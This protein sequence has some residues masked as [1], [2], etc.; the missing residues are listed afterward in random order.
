[1]TTD[2]T[3]R[4]VE[5]AFYEALLESDPD[6]TGDFRSAVVVESARIDVIFADSDY[7]PRKEDHYARVEKL[8]SKTTSPTLTGA[9]EIEEGQM[10]V[11]I[12]TVIGGE[13]IVHNALEDEIR[14][15]F[16]LHAELARGDW[17]VRIM[18]VGS[19][20]RDR[21]EKWRRQTLD[22]AYIAHRTTNG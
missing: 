19:S 20:E 12:N 8:A 16:R 9:F 2:L 18:S 21:V 11:E 5:Y 13:S 4:S 1:M 7:K 6:N 3:H 15:K 10:R 14:S 17:R 22:I